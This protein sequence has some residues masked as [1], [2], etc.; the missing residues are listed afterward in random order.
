MSIL[1]LVLPA[2]SPEDFA[3]NTSACSVCL[4]SLTLDSPVQDQSS[5]CFVILNDSKKITYS[6]WCMSWVT[7]A[8][9][10]LFLGLL[11]SLVSSVDS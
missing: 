11:G 3:I 8:G 9:D 1:F 4:S 6:S 2:C 10:H 7:V 5:I